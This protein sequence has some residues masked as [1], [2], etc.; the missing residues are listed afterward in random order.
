MQEDHEH[1]SCPRVVGA[2]FIWYSRRLH[3]VIASRVILGDPAVRDQMIFDVQSTRCN[4][5]VANFGG[6]V[7]VTSSELVLPILLE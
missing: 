4:R 3:V 7:G 6:S 1:E 2:R 5:M